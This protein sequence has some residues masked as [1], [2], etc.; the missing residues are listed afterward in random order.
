MLLIKMLMLGPENRRVVKMVVTRICADCWLIMF[1]LDRTLLLLGEYVIFDCC[2]LECC[3]DHL[4]RL[5]SL[6]YL[7]EDEYS[8]DLD[9]FRPS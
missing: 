2:C 6:A 3:N 9:R 7:E 4:L 5:L 1:A 8:R